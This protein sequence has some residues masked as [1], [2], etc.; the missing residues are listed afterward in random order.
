MDEAIRLAQQAVSADG[1]KTIRYLAH[2]A[3]VYQA[4]ERW[5]DAIADAERA[6]QVA[7]KAISASPGDHRALLTADAQYQQIIAVFQARTR[8]SGEVPGDTYVKLAGYF[9]ERAKLAE[10]LALH[11]ALAVLAAGV[12]RTAPNSPA[13]LLELY[14]ATLAEAGRT[15]DAVA[16]YEKLL[17]ADPGNVNATKQLER[18]RSQPALRPEGC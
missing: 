16:A 14:A 3:N 9:R 7:V 11:D 5:D 6:L 10:R 4:A 17:Q 1:G 2:L 18:L 15:A 12:E 8:Q 13:A